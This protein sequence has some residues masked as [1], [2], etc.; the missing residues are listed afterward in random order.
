MVS[1][2]S[3]MVTPPE[4][5]VKGA[6]AGW[7]GKRITG[8]L[9]AGRRKAL[10]ER[11]AKV[12]GRYE[13]STRNG[14]PAVVGTGAWSEVVRG[15][16]LTG[17]GELVV[18]L[19]KPCHLGAN[20]VL[21]SEAKILSY[22]SSTNHPESIAQFLGFDPVASTL[23]MEYIEGVTLAQYAAFRRKQRREQ[24]Y[25]LGSEPVIGL[26]AWLDL[27]SQLVDAFVYLKTIGVVHGDVS[28]YNVLV[29]Q[30]ADSR[31]VPVIIDFS[32]GHLD[33]EGYLPPAVSATTTSFAAPEL[34][35]AHLPPL[36]SPMGKIEKPRPVPTFASD[37]Y[38]LAMTLLSA[39][40]GADVYENAGRYASIYACQGQPLEWTRNGDALMIVGVRSIVSKVLS[41]CFGQVSEGRQTIEGLR[42]QIAG[43]VDRSLA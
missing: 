26:S 27:S 6:S 39:A 28:W 40:I 42:D 41:G 29:K 32:S 35:K 18:A 4:T 33:V 25:S 23:V 7:R 24:S 38:G 19:K 36:R 22:I 5:P 1:K 16:L 30:L 14:R 11:P 17:V 37:L 10:C 3:G 8:S 20:E 31:M 21:E 43:C 2:A 13:E 15:R 9:A 12:A 34:L